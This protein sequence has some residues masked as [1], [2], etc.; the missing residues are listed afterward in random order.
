MTNWFT[1]QGTPEDQ[2]HKFDR[3]IHRSKW[4]VRVIDEERATLDV[5]RP[6]SRCGGEGGSHAWDHTGYTCFECRGT[7]VGRT[8]VVKLYTA[9]KLEKLNAAQAKRQAKATEKRA[10]KLAAEQAAR[11]AKSVE[12]RVANKIRFPG[13]VSALQSYQGENHFLAE[14]KAKFNDGFELTENQANAIEQAFERE[15]KR[16]RWDEMVEE[17]LG[18]GGHPESGRQEVDGVVLTGK[19][20]ESFY[21]STLKL[22][23]LDYRGFKVW[24]SA[25]KGFSQQ[26]DRDDE[27]YL[28]PQAARGLQIKMKVTL[29]PKDAGFAFGTRPVLAA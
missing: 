19:Y 20:Q 15:E 26:I 17:I 28:I 25:P 11:E 7:G 8:E 29:E 5:V 18:R 9:E 13:A 14:M 27:G 10:A 3:I 21:G 12:T 4:G 1:R 16:R 2:L 23:V 6:C 22:L 24:C